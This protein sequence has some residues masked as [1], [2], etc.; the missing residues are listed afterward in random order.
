MLCG[1]VTRLT[2]LDKQSSCKLRQS[3]I[4]SGSLDTHLHSRMC[5][6]VRWA[7]LPILSGSSS[8][9]LHLSKIISRN[10]DER[11]NASGNFFKILLPL[12]CE[13]PRS[14]RSKLMNSKKEMILTWKRDRD[15]QSVQREKDRKGS[16]SLANVYRTCKALEGSTEAPREIRNLTSLTV[17]GRKHLA[18]E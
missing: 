11:P 3:P 12:E 9:A 15:E 16:N 6:L 5:K 1:S 14:S 2:H 13:L 17:K 7:K 4:L 18:C 8:K 10:A